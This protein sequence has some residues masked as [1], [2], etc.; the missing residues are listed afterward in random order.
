M[1]K[2]EARKAEDEELMREVED[3]W[4]LQSKAALEARGQTHRE[5]RDVSSQTL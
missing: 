5:D 1:P 2:K 3:A 4:R